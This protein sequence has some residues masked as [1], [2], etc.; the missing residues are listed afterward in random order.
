MTRTTVVQDLPS[1][2]SQYRSNKKWVNVSIQYQVETDQSIL[3]KQISLEGLFVGGGSTEL[4][5]DR[6]TTNGKRWKT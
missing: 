5:G 2:I 3:D 1:L 6:W 4:F